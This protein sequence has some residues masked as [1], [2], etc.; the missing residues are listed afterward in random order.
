M[1][2]TFFNCFIPYRLEVKFTYVDCTFPI[3]E[4]A[5]GGWT[6]DKPDF[7]SYSTQSCPSWV[8][9][10]HGHSI[11]ENLVASNY[12]YSDDPKQAS[13]ER[14]ITDPDPKKIWVATFGNESTTFYYVSNPE[15]W[16]VIPWDVRYNPH[17]PHIEDAIALNS[18]DLYTDIGHLADNFDRYLFEYFWIYCYGI[19]P[20]GNPET[21]VC[22]AHMKMKAHYRLVL[23]C[24]NA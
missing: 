9:R 16:T 12:V 6:L 1:L 18:P 2:A 21:V 24:H 7:L 14:V 17:K 4:M 19:A 5:Y 23:D 10:W 15:D 22:R 20:D 3:N 13:I 11:Y 8:A